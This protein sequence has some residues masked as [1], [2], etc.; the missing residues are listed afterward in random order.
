MN[1]GGNEWFMQQNWQQQQQQ[2]PPQHYNQQQLPPPHNFFDNSAAVSNQAPPPPI[3]TVNNNLEHSTG[4]GWGDW[5]DWNQNEMKSAQAPPSLQSGTTNF[6]HSEFKRSQDVV[7]DSFKSN[8]NWQWQHNQPQ[9]QNWSAPQAPKPQPISTLPMQPVAPHF[10]LPTVTPEQLQSNSL[11]NFSN[12]PSPLISMLVPS[13]VPLSSENQETVIPENF[14]TFGST[15]Q[16]QITLP[17]RKTVDESA[18]YITPAPQM[19]QNEPQE[20][21]ETTAFTIQHPVSTD[22]IFHTNEETKFSGSTLSHQPNMDN[23][24]PEVAAHTQLPTSTLSA[25]QPGT[26]GT[27][28]YSSAPPLIPSDSLEDRERFINQENSA[29]ERDQFLNQPER[30]ENLLPPPVAY[31][32][33]SSVN[34]DR[35]QY[36]QTSHLSEDDFVVLNNP[37]N[38]DDVNLPPPG[39]SRFVLGEPEQTE[40]SERHADGEDDDAIQPPPTSISSETS[41]NVYSFPSPIDIQVQ[42]VV[43]GVESM[44]ISQPPVITLSQQ[45][46]S[47]EIDLD[48]ENI[49][50]QPQV[51]K[52]TR[53][54]PT[55]GGDPTSNELGKEIPSSLT[56]EV[57]DLSNSS[58]ANDSDHHH[59]HRH[60]SKKYSARSGKGRKRF[61]SDDSEG[62]SERERQRHKEKER[63][64]KDMLRDSDDGESYRQKNSKKRE[65]KSRH[66]NR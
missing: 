51:N 1:S 49:E 56:S 47:R 57:K 30:P 6:H 48:G 60:D 64:R 45:V 8:E 34:D 55:I 53:E 32:Q 19:F 41:R 2:Q 33:P 37:S 25:S 15:V 23:I 20:N 46:E 52:A 5:D 38:D 24:V 43:T 10:P 22:P 11:P 66:N 13:G 21:S 17:N 62:S 65:D 61:D 31:Q 42:R 50:D 40:N 28:S 3:Q 9:A 18:S 14:E 12:S 39:L 4:D 7:E 26:I 44:T 27:T 35:N 29:N 63:K 36:L 16:P 59:H 54:E 58:T